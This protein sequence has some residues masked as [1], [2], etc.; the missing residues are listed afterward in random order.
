VERGSEITPSADDD[1]DEANEG[2]LTKEGLG[3]KA[4]E[5]CATKT[6]TATERNSMMMMMM[7]MGGGEWSGARVVVGVA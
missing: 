6:A 2:L 1:D 5:A 3:R 4:F 7:M